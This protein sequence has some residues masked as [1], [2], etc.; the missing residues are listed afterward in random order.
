M[1]TRHA[2]VSRII[3]ASIFIL[4]CWGN[5][6]LPADPLGKELVVNGDMESNAYWQAPGLS[7]QRR[8]AVQAENVINGETGYV[9][10]YG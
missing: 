3:L 9:G 2:K 4:F 7:R 8:V 6:T 10:L 5:T 1:P